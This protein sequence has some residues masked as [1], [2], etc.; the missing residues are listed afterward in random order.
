MCVVGRERGD[1]ARHERGGR[2]ARNDGGWKVASA[3]YM[4][5]RDNTHSLVLPTCARI[6][7]LVGEVEVA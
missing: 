4:R 1:P 7:V 3:S 2:R 5:R 6:S